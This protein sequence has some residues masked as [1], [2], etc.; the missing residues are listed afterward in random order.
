MLSKSEIIAFV[1]A[2]DLSR[3][4]QFYH[5]TL[6]LSLDDD[7]QIALV[8][9]SKN[10]M[11]RVTKVEELNPATYTVLGWKVDNI[12]REVRELMQ[13]GVVFERYPGLPQDGLGIWTTEDGSKV[14]WF[15][16]PDGNTLSLTQFG[17]GSR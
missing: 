9:R 17:K 14:A 16:D 5:G 1:G 4:K 11:L 8:F 13:R 15:K 2:R 10:A 7:G 3:A 6:G 12:A